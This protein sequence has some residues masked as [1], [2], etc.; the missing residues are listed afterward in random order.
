MEAGDKNRGKGLVRLGVTGQEEDF[1]KAGE[2][3]Y[4]V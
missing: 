4:K 2:K 1:R 3:E